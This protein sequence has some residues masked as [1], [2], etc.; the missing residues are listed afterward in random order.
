[1]KYTKTATILFTL[2]VGRHHFDKRTPP[3]TTGK[4]RDS[5]ASISVMCTCII[6]I[7]GQRIPKKGSQMNNIYYNY[8]S[9]QNSKN[10]PKIPKFYTDKIS[11]RHIN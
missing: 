1:M 4:Q 2:L 7:K 3:N 9:G 6:R 11:S 10:F 5:R 8:F